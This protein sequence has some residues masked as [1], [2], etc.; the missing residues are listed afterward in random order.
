MEED[1][2]ATSPMEQIGCVQWQ[3]ILS[4]AGREGDT[5]AAAVLI[6]E[7][8][9]QGRQENFHR[10]LSSLAI[11]SQGSLLSSWSLPWYFYVYI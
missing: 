11:R 3:Q 9:I 4:A 8:N 2:N 6:H 7:M 5:P 1:R 10:R